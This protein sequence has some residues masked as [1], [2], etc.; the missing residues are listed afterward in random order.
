MCWK[1]FLPH[2]PVLRKHLSIAQWNNLFLRFDD[3]KKIYNITSTAL[4][5]QIVPSLAQYVVG[6]L[7]RQNNYVKR[8]DHFQTKERLWEKDAVL[9]NYAHP[10]ITRASEHCFVFIFCVIWY[11]EESPLFYCQGSECQHC[12]CWLY[13][14]VKDERRIWA[15]GMQIGTH[16][17]R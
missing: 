16:S 1:H 17:E 7:Q 11:A 3:N 2:K 6:S 13:W 14:Y 8:K 9:C 4:N 12:T 5:T 10:C 15:R